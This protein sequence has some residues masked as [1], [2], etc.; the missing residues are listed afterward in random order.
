MSLHERLI[1]QLRVF[2]EIEKTTTTSYSAPEGEHDDYVM[3]LALAVSA[4]LISLK[5]FLA[6]LGLL[7]SW[8]LILLHSFRGTHQ[9][10]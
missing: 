6:S 10:L 3:A 5:L 7:E 4:A 2:Q 8:R 1:N 9:C